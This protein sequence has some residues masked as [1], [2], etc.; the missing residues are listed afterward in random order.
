MDCRAISSKLVKRVVGKALLG[1]QPFPHVGAFHT[2]KLQ[3]V[4][5]V[6]VFE[7][8]SALHLLFCAVAEQ[9]GQAVGG[10]RELIFFWLAMVCGYLGPP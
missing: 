1:K 9:M 3:I 8:M 10:A 6:T 5:P 2:Q 4:V 7:R